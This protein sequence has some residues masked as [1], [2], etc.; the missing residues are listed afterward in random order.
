M[1]QRKA[2]E[3]KTESEN[4]IIIDTSDSEED[5]V[6]VIEPTINDTDYKFHKLLRSSFGIPFYRKLPASFEIQVFPT[7]GTD[8]EIPKCL[9][10]VRGRQF[11]LR[12]FKTADLIE[13]TL[14]ILKSHIDYYIKGPEETHD[15]DHSSDEL[16]CM[17]QFLQKKIIT[18]K[19]GLSKDNLEDSHD[20]VNIVYEKLRELFP[21]SP[22]NVL[23]VKSLN[24]V[25]KTGGINTEAALSDLVNEFL[26]SSPR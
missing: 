15:K 10:D 12:G 22:P 13:N 19:H 1:D 24:H 14:D 6:E 23:F 7:L 8:P 25:A 4:V 11:S 17:A 18:F 26:L 21:D 16:V 3:D 20:P 5:E 2:I 9:S